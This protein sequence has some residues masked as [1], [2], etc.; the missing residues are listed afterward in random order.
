MA[1]DLTKDL[2]NLVR[3]EYIGEATKA[4]GTRQSIEGLKSYPI[5]SKGQKDVKIDR[6]SI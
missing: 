5:A 6:L 1:D 2:T 3:N 4:C